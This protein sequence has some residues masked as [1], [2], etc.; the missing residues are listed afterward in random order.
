MKKTKILL[1]F[2]TLF[3]LLGCS[4]EEHTYKYTNNGTD[5]GIQCTY[6]EVGEDIPSGT[7]KIEHSNYGE[8]SEQRVY[9]VT[10]LTEKLHSC[11]D[12]DISSGTMYGGVHKKNGIIE[13]NDGEYLY[14]TKIQGGTKSHIEFIKEK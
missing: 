2:F 4:N 5:E 11:E 6:F 3:L 8:F 10:L 1:L 14:V 9:I 13:L 12:I 7:Y